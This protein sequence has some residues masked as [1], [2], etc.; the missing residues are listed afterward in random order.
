MSIQAQLETKRQRRERLRQ[1]QSKRDKAKHEANKVVVVECDYCGNASELITGEQLYPHRR[2]LFTKVFWRCDDCDAHVGC[3]PETVKPLGRLANEQLRK[4]K[5]QAHA[6]FDPLWRSGK[7]TRKGAYGWL[8]DQLEIPR[9][10]THIGMF[11]EEMCER[12][13]EACNDRN[14]ALSS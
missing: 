10:L 5:M 13:I 6:K 2:D 8:S 9:R 7:W 4:L 14:R 12:V 11:D 3:H 1:E